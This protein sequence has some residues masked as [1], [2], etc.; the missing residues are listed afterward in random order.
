MFLRVSDISAYDSKKSD[1]EM[2][3]KAHGQMGTVR[4]C[5]LIP[6]GDKIVPSPTVFFLQ[7]IMPAAFVVQN[8]HQAGVVGAEAFVSGAERADVSLFHTGKMLVE[9]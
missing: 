8:T 9:F 5:H 7:D 6:L 4:F 1:Y 3:K 2:M